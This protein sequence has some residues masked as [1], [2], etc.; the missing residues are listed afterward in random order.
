M[1]QSKNKT[2]GTSS[3]MGMCAHGSVLRPRGFGF[4]DACVVLLITSH[5][6]GKN[7]KT[8]KNEGIIGADVNTGMNG[9]LVLLFVQ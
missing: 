9:S 7:S 1:P 6:C 4:R 2:T 5:W 3:H 8:K